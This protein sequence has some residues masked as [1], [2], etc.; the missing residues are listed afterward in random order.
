MKQTTYSKFFAAAVLGGGFGDLAQA[1]GGGGV[2]GA[3]K[4]AVGFQKQRVKR[5]LL[6]GGAGFFGVGIEQQC[7]DAD[8][9]AVPHKQGGFF[10]AAGKGVGDAALGET[11]VAHA[12]DNGFGGTQAVQDNGAAVR[13]GEGKLVLEDLGLAGARFGRL[14]FVVEIQPDFADQQR[15]VAMQAGIQFGKCGGCRL[16]RIPRVDADGGGTDFRLPLQNL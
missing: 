1:G 14:G 5:Q 10:K 8:F 7:A 12:A 13:L 9:E 15:G 11:G 16:L 2:F 4:R 6:G 3:A